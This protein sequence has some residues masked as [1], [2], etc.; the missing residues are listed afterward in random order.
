MTA[1]EVQHIIAVVAGT[2]TDQAGDRPA[3]LTYL[4]AWYLHFVARL[5][6]HT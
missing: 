3:I 1:I 5:R 6:F 2:A 4:V